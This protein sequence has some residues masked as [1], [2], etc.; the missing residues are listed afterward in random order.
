MENKICTICQIDKPLSGFTTYDKIK[1]KQLSYCMSCG[2]IKRIERLNKVNPNR[3]IKVKSLIKFNKNEYKQKWYQ[4]NKE[5]IK[6]QAKIN[7]K[8]YK[9]ENSDKIKLQSKLYHLKTK[10]KDKE[11]RE[12]NKL[13]ISNKRKEY[14]KN[15]WELVRAREKLN[16]IKKREDPFY[17]LKDAIRHRVRSSIKN[18]GYSKK[19]KTYQILGC[20]YEEFKQHLESKWEPWM[21]WDNYGKYNGELNHGWDIDHI[22]PISDTKVE[23]EILKLNHYTNLQPLCS[24]INRV[25]KRDSTN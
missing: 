5:R 4:E 24:Y 21:N 16:Q 25:I 19:S 14:R 20:S 9:E 11:Y 13:I 10:D 22:N 7:K 17:R 1:N 23:E 2:N 6:E 3:K 18:N 8:K 15:N 12:A